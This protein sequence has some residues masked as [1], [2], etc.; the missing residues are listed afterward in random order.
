MVVVTLAACP[1]HVDPRGLLNHSGVTCAAAA[2]PKATRCLK[3]TWPSSFGNKTSPG[4]WT[5]IQEETL[6]LWDLILSCRCHEFPTSGRRLYSSLLNARLPPSSAAPWLNVTREKCEVTV[7]LTTDALQCS[8]R[9]GRWVGSRDKPGNT[10]EEKQQ[11]PESPSGLV[12]R[13]QD[14]TNVNNVK[15]DWSIP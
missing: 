12:S 5:F 1:P 14:C 15:S 11:I 3:A 13:L 9:A 6:W 7:R 8:K 2:A 4:F 10:E